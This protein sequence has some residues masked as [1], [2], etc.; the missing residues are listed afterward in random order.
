MKHTI[1]IL[2]L[3]VFGNLFLF[4]QGTKVTQYD[5]MGGYPVHKPIISDSLSVNGKAFEEANLLKTHLSTE[6]TG[7]KPQVLNADTAGVVTF[8]VPEN[9]YSLHL[10]M[11][12]VNANQFVKEKM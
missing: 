4:G 5:Y 3:L 2:G 6:K 7:I 12:Y 1:S 10:L 11:F 9:Q 8:D